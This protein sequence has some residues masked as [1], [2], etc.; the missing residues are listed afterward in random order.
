MRVVGLFGGRDLFADLPAGSART[1]QDWVLRQPPHAIWVTGRKPEGKGWRLDPAYRGDG[2]RWLE[3]TGRVEW[4]G[5]VP[6]LRAS[7][8]ALAREPAKPDP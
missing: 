2:V 1:M 8:V 4:R 7:K 5:G 3:V 6:V